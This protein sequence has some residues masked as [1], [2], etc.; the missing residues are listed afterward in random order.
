MEEYYGIYD[1]LMDDIYY[2]KILSLSKQDAVNVFKQFLELE[3]DE[4]L[5]PNKGMFIVIHASAF[6]FTLT[7]KNLI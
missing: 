2:A 6:D 4:I 5:L 3:C 7:S 1:N